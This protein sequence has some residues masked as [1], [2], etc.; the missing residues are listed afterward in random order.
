MQEDEALHVAR[1]LESQKAGE[2]LIRRWLDALALAPGESLA[3]FGCGLHLAALLASERV[4]PRGTV[5]AVDAS[6]GALRLLEEQAAQRAPGQAAGS[7]GATEAPAP[8][9]PVRAEAEDA[10]LPTPVDA[11]LV[12]H[13]LRHARRPVSVLRAVRRAL[14]GRGRAVVAE[15]DP[16]EGGEAGLA[17]SPR[18]GEDH[19]ARWLAQAGFVVEHV[20]TDRDP[21]RCAFLVRPAAQGPVPGFETQAIHVGQPPDPATGAVVVPIYQT[22]TFA[23]RAPGE[24]QGYEYARTGNPTRSALEQAL[25]ALEGG[26]YGLAFASGMAAIAAVGYLLRPGQR[27]LVPGDVYGGTWRLFARVLSPWGIVPQAVDMTRPEDALAPAL[28]QGGAGLVLVESPTNPLLHVIDIAAVAEIAH[29]FGVRLAVDNT[30]ASPYL[31]SPLALGA[32][33]VIHSTTKYLGGHSDVVGGGVVTNDPGLHQELR[34]V[35]N[36]AGGVPGPFDAWLVLRGIKTLA[37]RMQRHCQSAA[38][39]AA[40]LRQH[41]AVRAVHYPGL[42]DHPGHALAARQM[43]G[44]F[45]GMVSFVAEGGESA[46]RRIVSSTRLFTLGESLGGVE[47]L[48][49]HPASMTHLSLAGS[50]LAVDPALVRLSV[51][52]EDPDD[53]IDDLHG[54]LGVAARA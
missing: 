18:I 27:V 44:G 32:D 15:F 3:D 43:H 34:F 23:Q 29:R 12:T 33:L 47:S 28:E 22:S 4:G 16:A 1:T 2:R 39:V 20:L 21:E 17:R 25:A 50:G 48:I 38:R 37:V 35:Q 51:G 31:Q 13:V 10:V 49:E 45:G 8:I 54:A 24:H 42:P 9:V 14:G 41:P 7:A 6:A 52:L 5:Y 11:A 53:L 19:L 30:F 26:K 46:A 36:A 40:F